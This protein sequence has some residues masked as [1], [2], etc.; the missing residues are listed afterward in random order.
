[1]SDASGSANAPLADLVT[2]TASVAPTAGTSDS[3]AQTP[4]TF[5]KQMQ[6]E[7]T[8]KLLSVKEDR[9]TSNRKLTELYTRVALDCMGSLI[10]SKLNSHH[11]NLTRLV[12]ESIDDFI[13][14]VTDYMVERVSA[15]AASA[16][17]SAPAAAALSLP[18][19][20][21]P[22]IP[23]GLNRSFALAA[24]TPPAD[25]IRMR[26]PNCRT[27]AVPASVINSD[28]SINRKEMG[29]LKESLHST[30]FRHSQCTL[31]V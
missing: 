8:D 31:A 11:K 30:V 29:V 4:P 1:M 17:A 6:K 26:S 7:L 25:A 27:P 21:G 19:R 23:S 12:D 10:D 16:P 14:E 20:F 13:G 28:G 24:R 9:K 3:D 15:N 22:S 5:S 2:P 18:F